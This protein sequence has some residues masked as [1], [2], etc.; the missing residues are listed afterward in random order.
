MR[1]LRFRSE[2]AMTA[3]RLLDEI[4]EKLSA[5]ATSSPARDLERNAKV[6]LNG[7]FSR[8]E[9]VTR[10]EFDI[11]RELLDRALERLAALEARLAVLEA[12]GGN[13]PQ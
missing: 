5:I 1:R 2:S 3:P 12:P 6:L 4:T 13:G 9:L 7:A 10:E 11:Q 8:L